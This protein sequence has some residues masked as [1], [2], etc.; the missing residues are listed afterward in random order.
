MISKRYAKANNKYMGEKFNPNEKSKFIQYLD[1]NNLYGWAMSL[2]LPVGGFKWMTDLKNWRE[3]SDQEGRGCILEVDLEY[4]KKLRDLHNEYPLASERIEI[5][6]VEKLIPNLNEKKKY[7]LHHKNLK[8]YLDLGLTLTKIH[9]G[10]V[11][12][13]NAWLKPYIDLNKNLSSKAQNEFE[14]DFFKLMNNNVFGK[15]LE[16]ICNWVNIR[17]VNKQKSLEKCAA[18]PN[19]DHCTIF[20]ENLVAVHMK[21]PELVFNKPVYLGASIWDLSKTLMY[22]FHDNYIKKK[23]RSK[24]NLLFTD[25]DSLCYEIETEDFYKDISADVQEKFDTSN[26]T[27]NHPSGIPTGI[28][29]KV[30]GMFK[31]EAGGEIIDEF[32]GLRAKLYAIKKLDGEEEKS[33][34]VSREMA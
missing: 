15:T 26:V 1:A 32:V 13:E 20:D 21:T 31:D 17:L 25:T 14:K 12:N 23:F 19:F 27:P 34:R 5:S 16:N 29:K 18:K 3:F 2:P 6:K 24:A 9:R 30:P 4:P 10:N 11:F 8:Q 28:N 7:V 33:V 22:D